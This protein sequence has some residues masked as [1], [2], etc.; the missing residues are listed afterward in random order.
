MGAQGGLHLSV[1]MES[2]DQ[3][4]PDSKRAKT[5]TASD[6]SGRW[7]SGTADAYDEHS[8]LDHPDIW[9]GMAE[10]LLPYTKGKIVADLGCADGKLSTIIEASE[11]VNVDPYPPPNPP[12]DIIEMDGIKYLESRDDDSLDI[13]VTYQAVH[14]MDRA[15]LDRQLA[16]VLRKDG[17]AIHISVSA[18]TPF[19]GDEAFNSVFV[20]KGFEKS[21]SD[22]GSCP[23]KVL[24]VQRPI[25]YQQL[26]DFITKRTWSN[27]VIMDQ[28]EIEFLASQIPADLREITVALDAYVHAF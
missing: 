27:L 11:C 4:E 25:T 8:L 2:A 26:T 1:D 24:E 16:R 12:R 18:K 13:V 3:V 19:F 5:S 20:S 7:H 23:T 22:G 10:F 15:E 28:K 14:F 9:K 21:G 6:D 17:R